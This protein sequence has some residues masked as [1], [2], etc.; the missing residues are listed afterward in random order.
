MTTKKTK[1]PTAKK[2]RKTPDYRA[3]KKR[4]PVEPR[5]RKTKQSV[6]EYE[7]VVKMLELFGHDE[8]NDGQIVIYTNHQY[9]RRGRVVPFKGD[10]K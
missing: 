8:D 3:V 4:A 6:S 5:G 7:M 9:D 10:N 1:K 2:K